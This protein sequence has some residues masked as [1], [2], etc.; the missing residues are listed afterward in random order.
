[1]CENIDWNVGRL[2]N[3]VN[4]LELNDDTVIVFFHDNGPNGARWNGDMKGRKGSTD[5]GGVRSPL[6]VKW[7]GTIPAGKQVS[8]IA[9]AIDLLPTLADLASVPLESTRRLDGVSLK[10]LLLSDDPNWPDRTIFSHWNG[11]VSARTQ[12][13]RLDHQGQLFDMSI[14]GGQR[15][16]LTDHADVRSRLRK[17]VEQWKSELLPGLRDDQRPFVIGH[18]DMQWTQLPAR[19]AKADGGIQRSNR[20]PNCSFFSNWKSTED[21][22]TWDVELP[23]N[24]DFE[25]ELY[26]TCPADDI[27]ATIELSF[28]DASIEAKVAIAH[29]PPLAGAEHDRSPRQESYVKDFKPLSMGT[30]S[31][32]QGRGPLT[33][34]ATD[35]PGSQ[36]M[37]FR[38]LMLRRVN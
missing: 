8:R 13:F 20:F 22:I 35:I 23:A 11:R 31:L 17:D 3:K 36:A 7:P 21:K 18:P 24:G 15:T 28:G 9:G 26:Y 38:L 2:L 34:Q 30:V 37:D 4:E 19:D 32:K 27:G 5:E 1:M 14:D 25:V 12:Q 29:D 16:P 6:L 10:P 33:L